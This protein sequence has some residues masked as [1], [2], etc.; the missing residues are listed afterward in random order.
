MPPGVLAEHGAWMLEMSML[1]VEMP[2]DGMSTAGKN[3]TSARPSG[4][5]HIRVYQ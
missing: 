5:F 1:R 2:A 4:S 3:R